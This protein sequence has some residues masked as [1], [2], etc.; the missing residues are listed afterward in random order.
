MDVDWAGWMKTMST[1]YAKTQDLLTAKKQKEAIAEYSTNFLPTVRA[2][3]GKANATYPVRFA[4]VVE[5][6]GWVRNLYALSAKAGKSLPEIPE[7]ANK[8]LEALR[9]H[10]HNMHIE[11]K[12]LKSNDF[13]YAV[14]MELAKK[15]RS[16]IRIKALIA[17]LDKAAP[18]MAVQAKA[19]DYAKA[20]AA[21]TIV[22]D[23]ILV[24]KVISPEELVAMKAATEK[25]YKAFGREF[26]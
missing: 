26:E 19:K 5:W 24:D 1:S 11:A 7:E 13:I 17:A 9:Q 15:K 20:K 18:S 12:V 23:P 25:F 21:Y 2:L 22:A 3:Y 10:F 14:R 8:Q 4:G 16:D 6:C